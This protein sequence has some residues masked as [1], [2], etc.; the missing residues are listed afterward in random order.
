M[1][2]EARHRLELYDPKTRPAAMIWDDDALLSAPAD[3]FLSTAASALSGILTGAAAPRTNPISHGDMLH[4][5]RLSLES[6][7]LMRR[8]LRHPRLKHYARMYYTAKAIWQL[9]RSS[10]Q[11]ASYRDYFQA[12]KSV[13]GISS[14]EPAGEIVR[15]FADAA[16]HEVVALPV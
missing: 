4:A 3:L 6:L 16:R 11:G 14:V 2:T 7:P 5:L 12:G 10:L 13:D 15:R 9:K 1:D 8:A